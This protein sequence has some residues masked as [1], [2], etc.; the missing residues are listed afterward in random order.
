[1]AL[2]E[3]LARLDKLYSL[4]KDDWELIVHH[5]LTEPV[6]PTVIIRREGSNALRYRFDRDTIEEGI[7]AAVDAVHREVVLGQTVESE[8]PVTNS[9]DHPNDPQWQRQEPDILDQIDAFSTQ[10]ANLSRLHYEVA[11]Y[12][13]ELRD[14][15]ENMT[16]RLGAK[17]VAE[18][19]N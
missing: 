10:D 12:I 16:L 19:G 7:E 1:M 11:R 18:R 17:R 15:V 2:K 14:E 6:C 13:R 9:D 4:T 8:S 5:T 3:T